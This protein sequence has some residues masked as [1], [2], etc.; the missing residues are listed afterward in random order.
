MC[1]L[2]GP[3]TGLAETL[4]CFRP[5]PN[6]TRDVSGSRMSPTLC[7]SYYTLLY[8]VILTRVGTAECEFVTCF[9]MLTPVDT[10]T[11]DNDS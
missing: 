10:L 3:V 1:L 2:D 6:Q 11:A 9:T 8:Y 7:H 4:I 5:P